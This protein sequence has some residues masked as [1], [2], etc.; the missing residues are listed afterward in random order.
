MGV[1]EK[2]RIRRNSVRNYG[3]VGG[4]AMAKLILALD[5]TSED[6]KEIL[7]RLAW[8]ANYALECASRNQYLQLLHN[9]S[10]K[11]VRRISIKE[12][13]NNTCDH[14]AVKCK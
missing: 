4:A 1:T 10:N 9:A 7:H 6:G 14:D 5:E 2:N 3:H 8:S 13:D 11:F 12:S